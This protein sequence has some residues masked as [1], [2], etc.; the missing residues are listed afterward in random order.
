MWRLSGLHDVA[1]GIVR[2][3]V[4]VC[5]A[6]ACGRY[7]GCDSDACGGAVGTCVRTRAVPT[8]S[9]TA[10]VTLRDRVTVTGV[11]NRR[12]GRVG[13]RRHL[14][15]R[16]GVRRGTASVTDVVGVAAVSLGTNDE[17]AA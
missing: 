12:G 14:C 5:T 11:S 7:G 1:E 16:E 13:V 9:A 4:L 10:A 3:S 6:A 2:R 17:P 15:S 8:V